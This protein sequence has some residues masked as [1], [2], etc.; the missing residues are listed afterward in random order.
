MTKK[1]TN[2]ILTIL[3]SLLL[4]WVFPW[5][6]VMVAALA[7]SIFIPLKRAAVFF[8]PF[9]AVFLFWAVY[10][11]ILSSANDFTLAKKISQLLMLGGNPYLLIAVT[12]ILGGI[13]A[14]MSAVL[15]K[16]IVALNKK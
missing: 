1:I 11:Y 2:F 8:V 3:V 12:G 6:S 7:T 16:Q 5:W 9:F 13:A 15:G 4:S 14:G 10:S